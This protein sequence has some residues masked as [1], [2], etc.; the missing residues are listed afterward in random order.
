LPRYQTRVQDRRGYQ[1]QKVELE[2]NT[3]EKVDSES[4]ND[5]KTDSESTNDEEIIHTLPA[6]NNI[7]VYATCLRPHL[8]YK[9]VMISPH[10]TSKQ[11]I[12]GLLSRFRMKHRDPKLFFLTMEV[13]V[14]QTFQTITLEDNSRPAEMI[15]CNPWGGCKFILRSK[16]GG[17]VKIYDHHIR[18]DSVYKSI[19][20]SRETTVSD[21]FSI[22]WSCYPQLDCHNLCLFEYSPAQDLERSLKDDQCPLELMEAW[23]EEQEYRLVVKLATNK[24][25]D[26][27]ITEGEKYEET[28]FNGVKRNSILRQ[29]V[30]KKNFLRSMVSEDASGHNTENSDALER[31]EDICRDGDTFCETDSDGS[32]LNISEEEDHHGQL[33]CE[34]MSTSDEEDV[35]NNSSV[36]CDSFFT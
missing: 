13:T 1:Q 30:R 4:S 22:L 27:N 35:I 21:T 33:K 9:T 32:E 28:T 14:N 36:I 5:E 26:C 18:P 20:I 16:T 19:I 25:P 8:A 7:R 2:N 11:V 23:G 17:L 3:D 10:T 12:L 34:S 6:T 29:S 24:V 15:S 31:S